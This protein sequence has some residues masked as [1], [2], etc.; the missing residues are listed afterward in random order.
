MITNTRSTV[1]TIFNHYDIYFNVAYRKVQCQ[2]SYYRS[3]LVLL[4][5]YVMKVYKGNMVQI[6]ETL[7]DHEYS[8]I[9]SYYFNQL[10]QKDENKMNQTI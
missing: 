7:N 1:E 8:L 5:D 3:H 2:T 4:K 6:I 9:T 10:Q